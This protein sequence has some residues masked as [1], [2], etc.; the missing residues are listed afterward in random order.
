MYYINLNTG[1]ICP[2]KEDNA[3]FMNI[4]EGMRFM[5]GQALCRVTDIKCKTNVIT[6]KIIKTEQNITS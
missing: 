5:V 1:V 2:D 3:N 4:S 6:L